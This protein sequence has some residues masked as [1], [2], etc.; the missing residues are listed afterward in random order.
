MPDDHYCCKQCG[1]Y[2]CVCPPVSKSPAKDDGLRRVQP[3]AS[4]P[5]NLRPIAFIQDFSKGEV[6]WRFDSKES[7]D[8]FIK[9]VN[10]RV[11][12]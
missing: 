9:L 4:I 5:V 12:N 6:T 11:L 1:Q 3:T 7:A 10:E 2:N 8:L